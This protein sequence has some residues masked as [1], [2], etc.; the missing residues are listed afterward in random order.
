MYYNIA[1]KC[2]SPFNPFASS[3]S[4][5]LTVIRLPLH[6]SRFLCTITFHAFLIPLL[7]HC[8][9]KKLGSI[10]LQSSKHEVFLLSMSP[11]GSIST[12]IEGRLC[13]YKI[14]GIMW[15]LYIDIII[16]RACWLALTFVPGVLHFH[17]IWMIFILCKYFF[18]YCTYVQIHYSPNHFSSLPYKTN[19]L[20]WQH[21]LQDIF[22]SSY[23][24]NSYEIEL[25]GFK[26]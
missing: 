11:F 25:H 13:V 7:T 23:H 10:S 15:S 24:L 14:N 21:C 22:S 26:G 16:C 19:I 20:E 18:F 2:T 1:Y 8:T 17:Q 4:L 3:S 5:S 9:E 6:I 12:L